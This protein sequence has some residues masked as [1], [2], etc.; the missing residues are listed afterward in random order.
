MQN[1][2]QMLQI[3]NQ[4]K[5]SPNPEVAMQNMFNGN[6][7]YSRVMEMTKGKNQDEIKQ[8]VKNLA[9]EKGIDMNQMQQM[10]NMFGIN[11]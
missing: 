7:V 6:P 5:S 9:K 3:L 2:M 11:L 10:A 4:I 8:I 1:P